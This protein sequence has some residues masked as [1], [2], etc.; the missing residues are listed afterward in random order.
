MLLIILLSG[1]IK[2]TRNKKGEK[3]GIKNGP[4]KKKKKTEI[5]NKVLTQM[6][7]MAPTPPLSQ[8]LFPTKKFKTNI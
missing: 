8:E 2:S 6:S 3:Q 5:Q 4:H 7:P 1:G